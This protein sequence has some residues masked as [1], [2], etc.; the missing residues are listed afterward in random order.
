[1]L[2]ELIPAIEKEY[3]GTNTAKTRFVDGCSKGGWVSLGL[4][5]YYPDTFNGCFSY[6]PDAIEFENYQLIN[7]YKD[8]NTYVNEFKYPRPVMR[9]TDGEPML[10]LKEFITYENVLGYSNSYLNSGGQFSAHT[11]LYSPKGEN[12]LQNPLLIL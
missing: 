4:Q 5:I 9:W 7:I 11:A 1:L 3:R 2:E 12:G 6:S 10:S 8:Q